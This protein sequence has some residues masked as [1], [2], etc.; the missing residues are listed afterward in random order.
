MKI[1]IDCRFWSQTGVGRY[2]RNLVKELSKIDNKNE[3]ILF[4]LSRD[5]DEVKSAIVNS[6][7]SIVKTNVRWHSLQEQILFPRI[8]NKYDL[9]LVHFPY[10]SHPIFYNKP[11]VVTIHDL[12]INHFPTGKAS[13][14]P[15][16]AYGL[17][18]LG[19]RQVLSHAVSKSKKIIVPLEFVKNDLVRTLNISSSKV[20]VT[21]E[22]FDPLIQEGKIS[23]E[24]L[25]ISKT[26]Y[27]IYVG[28]AYP[29][30]NLVKLIEGFYKAKLKDINFIFVG[31]D[32]FFYKQLEKNKFPN[33][34]FLHNVS[35][36]ELFH[37][38]KNS[39]AAVSASLMEG[40]G[41][42]PLE[43][44]GCNTIPV[45][46]RI[47][48]FV[49]VCKDVAIYFNPNDA[50]DIAEKIKFSLELSK[51][52]RE[53]IIKEG[54]RILSQFSW[55]KMTAQTLEIYESSISLR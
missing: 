36:N 7:W 34:H 10:F 31:K 1:G 52:E 23:E 27:F 2:T 45:I 41:L 40:F 17:K 55:E 12:I 21:P 20:L 29:H 15:L 16:P 37:L 19:Y 14:L 4:V 5:Y 39:I 50:D 3:Y 51:S 48:A 38:Y 44:L 8:L 47:P 35:D 46:S 32:D 11:F 26:P 43:A 53:K 9:D 49:E 22:G 42:L 24:I 13:T 54:A 30:K 33:L 18:L 28:N 25:Q 6:K